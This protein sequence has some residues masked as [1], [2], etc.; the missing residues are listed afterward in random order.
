MPKPLKPILETA[1]AILARREH[2]TLELTRK[3][4]TK[5]YPTAEIEPL[6]SHLTHKNFL[7]DTRYA[8]IR[9]RT[10]AEN[11]KW[12]PQRIR[13]E[14]SQSGI[15]KD[16][17]QQTLS[18]LNDAQ[19]WLSTA[20]NLLARKF[21]QPLP[22]CDTA[23]PS[24]GKKEALQAYQKEKAKRLSFLTRRGFTLEQALKALNLTE[25]DT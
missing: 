2:S 12:G 15:N 13:Q 4:R 9:A 16:L 19:D 11:S 10:R 1:L 20:R 22:T 17:T 18:Q 7:N 3:L 5:G 21:P 23:D 14:L 8:E 24:L 6:I 25:L